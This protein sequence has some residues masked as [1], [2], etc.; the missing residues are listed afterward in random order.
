VGV[1]LGDNP[2]DIGKSV[3]GII[4]LD[5]NRGAR[6]DKD[7]TQCSSIESRNGQGSELERGGGMMPS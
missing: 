7:C 3:I 4:D 6:F 5:R 1:K 2:Q